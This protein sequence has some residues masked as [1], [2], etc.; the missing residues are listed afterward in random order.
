MEKV[1]E[2]SI[3]NLQEQPEQP[4]EIKVETKEI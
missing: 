3:E 2:K 4:E 1:T